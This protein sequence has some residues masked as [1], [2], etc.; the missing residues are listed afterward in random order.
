M[1]IPFGGQVCPHCL[2]DKSSD[3][4]DSITAL[5]GALPGLVVGGLIGGAIGGLPIAV[6][7][8]LLGG[9]IG[10][11]VAAIVMRKAESRSTEAPP[12][13]RVAEADGTPRADV[14]PD[15]DT[16]ADR[17]RR[18]DQLKADGLISGKEHARK[19]DDILGSI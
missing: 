12:E 6:A 2:R 4:A 13:V 1:E 10:S 18:V 7:F 11:L 5:I 17:L 9:I 19:R 15:R 3:Q 16:V 8:G 14:Q